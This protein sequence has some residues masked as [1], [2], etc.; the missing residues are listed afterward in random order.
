MAEWS[1]SD[2]QIIDWLGIDMWHQSL[3]LDKVTGDNNFA[4]I[5]A[6]VEPKSPTILKPQSSQTQAINGQPSPSKIKEEGQLTTHSNLAIEKPTVINTVVEKYQMKTD[7]NFKL[8]NNKAWGQITEQR[9]AD[10]HSDIK[11]S[12]MAE[13][14]TGQVD[15]LA[16]H[17]GKQNP[18]EIDFLKVFSKNCFGHLFTLGFKTY[19]SIAFNQQRNHQIDIK[20]EDNLIALEEINKLVIDRKPRKILICG[21]NLAQLLLNNHCPLY[22]LRQQDF[23]YQGNIPTAVS[24]DFTS[25]YRVPK[26]KSLLWTDL[27]YLAKQ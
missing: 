17:W 15:I 20:S 5:I 9:Q 3:Q 16:I 10:K 23:Y 13:N 21:Q 2:L 19:L 26:L 25:I 14:H 4:E 27:K 24:V 1:K 11:L 22:Q 6:E 7:A 12:T 8:P 18:F